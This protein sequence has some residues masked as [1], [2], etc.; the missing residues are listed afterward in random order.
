MREVG[1]RARL[2]RLKRSSMSF[3]MAAF[4]PRCAWS[5]ASSSLTQSSNSRSSKFFRPNIWLAAVQQSARAASISKANWAARPIGNL[6][7]FL[8]ALTDQSMRHTAWLR[9]SDD[10]YSQN[11]CLSYT[12]LDERI[13]HTSNSIRA[14][15]SRSS[16]MRFRKVTASRPSTSR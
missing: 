15:S 5:S 7:S 9:Y 16:L 6:A 13:N 14:G 3:R 11:Q 8:F 1:Q 10:G 2:R 4:S 12:R